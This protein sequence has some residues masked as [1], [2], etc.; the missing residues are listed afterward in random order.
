[1][2]Q[3]Q[4]VSPEVVSRKLSSVAVYLQDLRRHENITFEE[5]MERHYEIERII[6]LLIMT[7]SDI[8][9]HLLSSRGEAVPSSYRAAFLR[10]GELGIITPEL[11]KSLS[12]S[13]GLRNILVHEYAEID[14]AI[15]HGSISV[16]LRDFTELISELGH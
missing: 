11:S 14:Y 10:A 6:E 3:G 13:A 7:S 8:V 4:V 2:Q 1:M 5:F 15:V 16:A 12:M 9:I